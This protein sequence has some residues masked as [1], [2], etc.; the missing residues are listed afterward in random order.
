LDVNVSAS[1]AHLSNSTDD[2]LCAEIGAVICVNN[3]H[4]K[5]SEFSVLPSTAPACAGTA[6]DGNAAAVVGTGLGGLLLQLVRIRDA[7]ET[8]PTKTLRLSSNMLPLHGQASAN[9]SD[10]GKLWQYYSTVVNKQELSLDDIIRK[11]IEGLRSHP[12]TGLESPK[13]TSGSEVLL[14]GRMMG[15]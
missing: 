14:W 12:E 1:D 2:P 5:A 10:V 13:R 15:R 9:K 7:H 8:T 3:S 11:G 6:T 4:I